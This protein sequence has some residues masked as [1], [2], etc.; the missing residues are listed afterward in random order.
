VLLTPP[1]KVVVATAPK[2]AAPE[3]ASKASAAV[4]EV[5]SAVE[6]AMKSE[7]EAERKVHA[8]ELAM[9]ST[10]ASWAPVDEAMVRALAGVEVPTERRPAPF[11]I[12]ELAK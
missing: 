4:V 1:V 8:R 12:P 11:Q 2:V 3:S 5:E 9:P 7:L 10:S 6:V